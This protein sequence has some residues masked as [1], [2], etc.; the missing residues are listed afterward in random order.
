MRCRVIIEDKLYIPLN[1]A[2]VLS[3]F[4]FFQRFKKTPGPEFETEDI[5]KSEPEKCVTCSLTAQA[6]KHGQFEELLVCKDC[7]TTGKE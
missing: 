6:N 5:L 4:L 3:F 7:N 2:K 1:D